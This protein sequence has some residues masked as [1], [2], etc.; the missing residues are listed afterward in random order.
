MKLHGL[1]SHAVTRH[2]KTK[3]K[4]NE[5]SLIVLNEIVLMQIIQNKSSFEIKNLCGNRSDWIR[6]EVE[7]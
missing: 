1:L 5:K 7:G 4:K 2:I 6:Q 3:E